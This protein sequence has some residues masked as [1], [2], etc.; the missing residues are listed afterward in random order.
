MP[1]SDMY[2]GIGSNIG[3]R[4][5]NLRAAQSCL[6]SV[7]DIITVSSIYETEPVGFADQPAFL[8]L[9]CRVRT[10]L[11]PRALLEAA[12]TAEMQLGRT[13]TFKNGPRTVDI[14]I[15]LCGDL[16]LNQTDLVIPHPRLSERAFVLVPLA[17][18]AGDVMHPILHQTVRALLERCPD[19]HWVRA[20]VKGEHVS[21]LR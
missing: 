10:S 19:K 14:D 12:R 15:L 4:L 21:T 1:E 3:D 2:L 6:A 9:A 11:D 18:I 8:N 20:T 13:H 17:E 16:C 5:A 7:V